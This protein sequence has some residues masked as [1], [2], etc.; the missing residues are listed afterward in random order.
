MADKKISQLP[1]GEINS[2]SIFPIVSDGITSRVSFDDMADAF[3]GGGGS[4]TLD[5]VLGQGSVATG[6]T[7][8][9]TETIT[10]GDD[11]ET[12]TTIIGSEGGLETRLNANYDGDL[13]NVVRYFDANGVSC[14]EY[15]LEDELSEGDKSGGWSTDGGNYGFNEVFLA[16][17]GFPQQKGNSLDFRCYDN[18]DG[19]YGATFRFPYK[20][21]PSSNTFTL[22]IIEN[23]PQIF[24]GVF[25]QEGTNDPVVQEFYNNTILTTYNF[26]RTNIGVYALQVSGNYLAYINVSQ[27]VLDAE[28][29]VHAYTDYEPKSNQTSFYIYTYSEGVFS[30]DVVLNMALEIGLKENV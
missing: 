20:N 15:K 3:G 29:R 28:S 4:Q 23:L 7:I 1:V 17:G 9:I 22:A 6:K 26:T 19:N 2:N 24:K 21:T 5:Q 8:T 18:P 16:E 25:N 14:R 30:D 12:Y 27:N 11:V 13:Y 10:S